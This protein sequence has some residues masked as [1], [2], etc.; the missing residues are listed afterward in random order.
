MSDVGFLVKVLLDAFQIY[1][2]FFIC[3]LGVQKLIMGLS[4]ICIE[5]LNVIISKHFTTLLKSDLHKIYG[6]L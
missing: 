1:I 4:L 2:V 6:Y 3:P 5:L